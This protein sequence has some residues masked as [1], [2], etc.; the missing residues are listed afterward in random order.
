MCIYEDFVKH[1]NLSL[2]LS[3]CLLYHVIGQ[4][5]FLL[6]WMFSG[7]KLKLI[8]GYMRS[9]WEQQYSEW[10]NVKKTGNKL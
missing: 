9:R 7:K 10:F 8:G 3:G 5:T 2:L 6:K 4:K 1:G